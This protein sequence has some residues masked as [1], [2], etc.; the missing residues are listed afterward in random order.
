MLISS[1]SPTIIL[2]HLADSIPVSSS[3]NLAGLSVNEGPRNGFS[4]CFVY[5]YEY[6]QVIATSHSFSEGV[7]HFQ[8]VLQ[9]INQTVCQPHCCEYI[10]LS[11]ESL[12]LSTSCM[13]SCLLCFKTFHHL[14]PL[15][16]PCL[17][18]QFP[19]LWVCLQQDQAQGTSLLRKG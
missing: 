15:D 7:S 6:A 16:I 11:N 1:A 3:W 19:M 8:S 14:P 9:I 13:H 18:S 10:I 4:F 5:V 17:T 12:Q 2:R